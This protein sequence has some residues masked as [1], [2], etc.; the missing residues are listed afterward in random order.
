MKTILR[1]IAL[2][3]TR[4]RVMLF[5]RVLIRSRIARSK[6]HFRIICVLRTVGGVD[7]HITVLS[8]VLVVGRHGQRKVKQNI[9]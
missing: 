8:A 1:G 4:A 9:V 3:R 5:K 6:I 2:Q 7:A